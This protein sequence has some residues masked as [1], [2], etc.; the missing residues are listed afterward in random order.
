[1]ASQAITSHPGSAAS[2]GR[3]SDHRAQRRKIGGARW[4]TPRRGRGDAHDGAAGRG[5]VV[6]HIANGPMLCLHPDNA[7]ELMRAQVTAGP[8]TA[9]GGAGAPPVD[10]EVMVPAH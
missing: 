5:F 1:M 3:K 8:T 4:R 6:L 2:A 10:R 9:R 7:R